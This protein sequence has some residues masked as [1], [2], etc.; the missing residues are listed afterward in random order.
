MHADLSRHHA[1]NA[2]SPGILP[3]TPGWLGR[4]GMSQVLRTRQVKFLAAGA[5]T[6]IADY[7]AF[8]VS[9][10]VMHVDLAV[11]TVASFL[12]GL[13][14][15]FGLNKLWVFE[16]GGN[17]LSRSVRQLLSYGVLLLFNI[18]FTYYFIA[19]LQDL[20][21]LDPR[22]SKPLAILIT[23]AWNYVIYGRVIFRKGHP[24]AHR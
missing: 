1:E 18:A 2:P 10:G 6:V 7:S 14:V 17:S 12:A 24:D 21:G 9:Y 15:S 16:S 4:G 3:S 22:I 23:T 19:G 11:A 8:F 5:L 13:V 20:Y